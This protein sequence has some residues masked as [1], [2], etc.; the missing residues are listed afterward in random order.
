MMPWVIVRPQLASYLFVLAVV[1]L[2]RRILAA[3]RREALGWLGVLAAGQLV[4]VNLHL[5]GVIGPGLVAVAGLGRILARRRQADLPSIPTPECVVRLGIATAIAAGMCAITPYG[6]VAASKS[7]AVRHDAA[8]LIVEW[9]PAGFGSFSQVTAVLALAVAACAVAH[10]AR[11]FRW[12]VVALIV[13]LGIGA[14]A[15]CRFAPVLGVVALP[16]L[17]AFG[18]TLRSRRWLRWVACLAAGAVVLLALGVGV[19]QVS[20]FGKLRRTS[21]SADL[22]AELP[23]G[24]RVL[25]DYQLGGALIMF[26]PDVK[27][28]VD[29]RTDL[30]GRAAIERNANLL[31]DLGTP[32]LS[33]TLD[34][35]HVRC[36][37]AP[38]NS[39]AVRSLQGEPNHW[40]VLG[41]QGG[42]TLLVRS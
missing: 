29:S 5:F 42:R 19:A 40:R 33:E 15:A 1:P 41:N 34:E 13:V 16:E 12:D 38:T 37:L 26:R 27:V 3:D 18:A 2:V 6:A 9:R 4:W 31:D 22:I 24:C 11:A 14:A 25:N 8:G 7:L 20:E 35:S 23:R 32:N 17:A 10:A 30:Y 21:N 39:Q 28:S 36:V